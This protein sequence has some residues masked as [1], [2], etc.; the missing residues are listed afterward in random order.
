MVT[1]PDGAIGMQTFAVAVTANRAPQITS[2]PV[3]TAGTGVRYTYTL[4]A[5]DADGGPLVYEVSSGPHGMFVGPS[6]GVIEWIPQYGQIGTAAVTARVRDGG[7]LVA[8]QTWSV[9]VSALN[10]PPIFTSQGVT[11]GQVGTRYMYTVLATDPEKSEINYRLVAYPYSA[12][13][14]QKTG[15]VSWTPA[16]GH[17]GPNVFTIR[18]QDAAGLFTDQTFTVQV[19]AADS[20]LPAVSLTSPVPGARLTADTPISGTV[21]DPNLRRWR[22]EYQVP[23]S[24]EWL[25][26]IEGTNSVVNGRLGIIPATFLHN[27]V[28]RIRLYAEDSGGSITTTPFDVS[29]DT[30]QLKFGGLSMSLDDVQIEALAS[31]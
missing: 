6:S 27:D 7:G 20:Q 23:G 25:R 2:R 9:V 29:I 24:S 17:S 22:V 18:A 1:D 14:D 21:S 19:G 16:S 3:T 4:T 11:Q 10:R 13:I 30:G 28:Y 15:I 12:S 31:P 26:L 5:S 8:T